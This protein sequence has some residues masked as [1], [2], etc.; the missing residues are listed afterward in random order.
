MGKCIENVGYEI[1]TQEN[2]LSRHVSTKRN[3]IGD[4][5]FLNKDTKG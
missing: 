2:D 4:T 1:I 3:H 5:L